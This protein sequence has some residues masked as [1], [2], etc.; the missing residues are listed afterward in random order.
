M[1]QIETALL[2]F[3]GVSDSQSETDKTSVVKRY[4]D[5][6]AFYSK[7]IP[8]C[9]LFYGKI[10]QNVLAQDETLEKE[11][12]FSHLPVNVGEEG[13]DIYDGL[14]QYFYDVVDY[15]D[16]KVPM[17]LSIVNLPPLLHI[18]LQVVPDCIFIGTSL[19]TFFSVSGLTENSC[20]R[21]NRKPMLNLTRRF[22]W[23]DSWTMRT[24]KRR[25]S[26]V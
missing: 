23:I 14:G 19:L 4:V 8:K 6:V 16:Q 26:R 13:F 21:G 12:L 18:Q 11:D 1:F 9:R 24:H 17:Q 20:S 25:P 10:R 2:K 22:T 15:K 7:P 5:S 3:D